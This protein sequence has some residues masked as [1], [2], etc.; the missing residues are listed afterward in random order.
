MGRTHEYLPHASVS[1]PVETRLESCVVWVRLARDCT[2]TSIA[3]QVIRTCKQSHHFKV[4]TQGVDCLLTICLWLCSPLLDLGHFFSFLIL[5]TVDR[6]PW[7]GNQP[8]ARP[9]PTHRTA[10]TQ[11]KR[12]QTSVP[13]VGFE[14]PIPASERAK[15][16]HALDGAATVIGSVY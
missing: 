10:Q 11:N 7:T 8:V 13:W 5:Y 14:H 2:P 3:L 1:R 15:T 12:T 4:I 6:T 16:V 9:L